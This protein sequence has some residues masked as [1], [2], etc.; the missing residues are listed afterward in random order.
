MRE[1]QLKTLIVP[2]TGMAVTIDAGEWNDIHPLNK[3]VVGVRLA[4]LA[5]KIAYN[6]KKIVAVAPYY[7]SIK[8]IGN[9][10]KLTFTKP[11]AN[12]VTN[13]GG[14]LTQIA[15]AGTNRKFVWAK[16]KIVGNKIIVWNDNVQQPVAV[17]YAWADNPAG[18][19]LI[20]AA[21]NFV[22]PFRTDNW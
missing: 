2:I 20:D 10:I 16:A 1:S 18:A 19:N 7:K 14:E 8:I 21:G 5:G 3:K 15:I 12:L 22:S 11:G 9:K 6:D 4:K 13:D 17:R